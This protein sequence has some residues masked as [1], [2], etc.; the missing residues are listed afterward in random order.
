MLYE[1]IT[2]P[3]RARGGKVRGP[4]HARRIS[5]YTGHRLRLSRQTFPRAGVVE[6]LGR[7]APGDEGDIGRIDDHGRA[8]ARDPGLALRIQPQKCIE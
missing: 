6:D 3:V 7:R 5:G 1:V 8:Q 4:N 2:G